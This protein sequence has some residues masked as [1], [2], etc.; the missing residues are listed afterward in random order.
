MTDDLERFFRERPP[1]PR[2]SH[3]A[4][5]RRPRRDSEGRC[6]HQADVLCSCR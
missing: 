3:V 4:I 2:D 1:K 5:P 6:R